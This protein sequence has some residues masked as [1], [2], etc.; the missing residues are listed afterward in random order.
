[1][2]RER[3]WQAI[4]LRMPDRIPRTEYI[5]HDAFIRKVTGLDTA[6]PE[7]AGKAGPALARALDYDFI[8]SI[9]E[10][11]LSRGRTTSM[12]PAVWSNTDRMNTNVACPFTDEEEVLSFDPVGEYG[13][14]NP[15]EAERQFRGNL[16]WGERAHPGAVFPGGRYNTLFSACIRS[17][18]WDMFLS[19]AVSDPERFDRVLEGFFR[20]TMAEVEAWIRA[21]ARVYLQ[22]DDI[23]WSSGPA[24]HP[25]W[26]RRY[27]FPRYR[28]LWAPLR[29]A[30]IKVLYCSDGTFTPLVDDI[31]AAGADGFIFEPTTSLE[32]IA[33]RYGKTKVI[34]GNADCRILMSGTRDDI[35]REVERCVRAGRDC[36]GYFLAVGNHIPNGIPLENVEAY[37]EIS[38]ELCR[39]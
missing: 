36:P 6:V 4:N 26:Y 33:E 12:G 22:H 25:D 1:M 30:G 19:A 38:A 27:I 14:P 29:E 20:I 3:G 28:K 15:R 18:G 34:V 11:P 7:E 5:S 16:E 17:F 35:R 32:L 39:R 24:F 10:V 37:F 13:I 31:A 8:W 21:G 9:A 2:S 23:C